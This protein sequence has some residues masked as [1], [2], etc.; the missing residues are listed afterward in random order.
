MV[1]S[2]PSQSR[3]SA[4]QAIFFISLLAFAVGLGLWFW[5]DHLSA[6]ASTLSSAPACAEAGQRDC[7]AAVSVTS[8]RTWMRTACSGR[9]ASCYDIHMLTVRFPDGRS[10]DLRM[11][12]DRIPVPEFAPGQQLTARVYNGV[13]EAVEGPPA[14][15]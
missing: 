8:E 7:L 9:T 2:A 14:R 1:R 15:G 13:V 11:V 4:A 6:S 3:L 5:G 12:A 10:Q